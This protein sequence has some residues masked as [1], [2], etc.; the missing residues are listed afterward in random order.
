MNPELFLEQKDV[1]PLMLAL[2]L[3]LVFRFALSGNTFKLHDLDIGKEVINEL[4]AELLRNLQAR[5]AE[6]SS[7]FLTGVS[8]WCRLRYHTNKRGG[9]LLSFVVSWDAFLTY[10]E[11]RQ[12]QKI[13]INNTVLQTSDADFR[14]AL[15]TME[16]LNL[17]K[18]TKLQQILTNRTL[19]RTADADQN[20]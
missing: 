15:L 14:N 11:S 1:T 8:D 5:L 13:L 6:I 18:K 12:L 17:Q 16:F 7:P 2:N 9:S 3:H 4:L 20:P 10:S 19:L